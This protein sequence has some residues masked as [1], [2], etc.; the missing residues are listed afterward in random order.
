MSAAP[1]TAYGPTAMVI[2]SIIASNGAASAYRV[3]IAC[4]RRRPG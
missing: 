2:S 4:R 1:S 3:F